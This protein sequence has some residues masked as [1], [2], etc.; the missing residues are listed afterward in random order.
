MTVE[1]TAALVLH[2]RLYRESSLLVESFCQDHGR[3]SLVAQRLTQRSARRSLLQPF[4]PLWLA[5][6]GRGDL[7]TLTHIEAAGRGFNL[8]PERLLSGLYI[9][10]LLL[11]LLPRH[12]PHQALF[13]HYRQALNELA[14]PQAQEP[15]LRRFEIRLL[16]ELGYGLQLEYA[17]DTGHPLCPH[18]HYVY[19]LA[20]GA[21]L[22]NNPQGGIPISGHSLLALA[23]GELDD[24]QVLREAK[25]LTRS[26]I[27]AH[28]DRPL[29][30]RKVLQ[31]LQRLPLP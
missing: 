17:A 20:Y 6:R 5:W 10:E 13:T 25:R 3:V 28:L 1:L 15:T 22:S 2:R 18:T 30:T 24:P 7:V 26:A 19:Q 21:V 29:Q 23:R 27:D 4:I 16:A 14:S 8:A 12:D 31:T 9:N 11:R